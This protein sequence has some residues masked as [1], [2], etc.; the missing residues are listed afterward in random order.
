MSR[1]TMSVIRQISRRAW[2]PRVVPGTVAV[3]TEVTFG[4]G[5]KGWS[6]AL[7]DEN[8]AVSL[9]E[10]EALGPTEALRVNMD[11]IVGTMLVALARCHDSSHQAHLHGGCFLRSRETDPPFPVP[12]PGTSV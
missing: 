1:E 8:L 5:R 9:A 10:A 6:V 11:E 7:G 4:L 2:L 3:W 12:F